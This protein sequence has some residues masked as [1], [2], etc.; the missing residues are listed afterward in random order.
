MKGNLLSFNLNPFVFKSGENC[1]H[2][3][4]KLWVVLFGTPCIF[5]FSE[6][7]NTTLVLHWFI[8][9][10]HKKRR[11]CYTLWS[12]GPTTP[13]CRLNGRELGNVS[14]PSHEVTHCHVCSSLNSGLGLTDPRAATEGC[15]SHP[16]PK[17]SQVWWIFFLWL[18]Y[19]TLF[20]FKL[21]LYKSR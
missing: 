14:F 11:Y 18:Y 5:D 15:L 7:K 3:A 19:G 21:N 6:E 13:V 4:K 9:D 2:R 10:P 12:Q 17:L 16:V 20:S 8:T 1:G